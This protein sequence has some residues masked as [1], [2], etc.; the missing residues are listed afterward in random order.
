ME[1]RVYNDCHLFGII[2]GYWMDVER[3]IQKSY[4]YLKKTLV[5]SSTIK[6]TLKLQGSG[7]RR[8][9]RR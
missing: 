5:S 1:E 7:H 3:K 8:E 2:V 9:E 4:E 6:T